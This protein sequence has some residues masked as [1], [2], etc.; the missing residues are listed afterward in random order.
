MDESSQQIYQESLPGTKHYM[1]LLKLYP[2]LDPASNIECKLLMVALTSSGAF[3]TSKFKY[4]ALSYA[5]K[6]DDNEVQDTNVVFFRSG[7]KQRLEDRWV[8]IKVPRNLFLALRR[9]RRSE[10]EQL[11]WVDSICINQKDDNERTQQ[12]A[13]MSNIYSLAD[14]VLIWLGE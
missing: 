10:D 3:S 4:A 8:K 7:S 13:L 1:R 12:V 9:L 14:K 6:E 2:A 11:L 5:W